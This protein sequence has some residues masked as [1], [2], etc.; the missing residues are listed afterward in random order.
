MVF[1][2]ASCGLKNMDM[3]FI[4]Y[5]I[6]VFKDV[7]PYN[8]NYILVLEM[9]W[10]LNAA[11]KVIKTWLPASAVKK[12]KFLN[13]SNVGEYV[14]EDQRFVAWGGTDDWEYEFEP[15]TSR[16][17]PPPPS[18]PAPSPVNGHHHEPEAMVEQRKV[19]FNE[20]QLANS[21][22]SYA[23]VGGASRTNSMLSSVSSMGSFRGSNADQPALLR[24][25]PENEVIFE[26]DPSGAE[27][28]LA[29][30][31]MSNISAGGKSLVFKVKTTN[32]D[33]FR[34]RPSVAL[35]SP[36]L[37]LTSATVDIKVIPT[38]RPDATI[39]KDKFLISVVVIDAPSEPLSQPQMAEIMKVSCLNKTRASLSDPKGSFSH[40]PHFGRWATGY[41]FPISYYLFS[42]LM[43]PSLFPI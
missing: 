34:V 20:G 38:A 33:R 43:P 11:W 3:E 41:P 12:I 7:T 5:M 42:H 9:P 4:Q 39:V 25:N 13:K 24:L 28:L 37:N 15:E 22:A 18:A 36:G 1:D 19:K 21:E 32:P 29:H 27:N 6:S 2:C 31:Q 16:P 14:A 23:P 8:L 17:T 40:V 30:I 26:R 10:V 35:L